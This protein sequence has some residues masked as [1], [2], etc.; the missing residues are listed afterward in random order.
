MLIKA[1][2]YK[3]YANKLIFTLPN[4][5]RLSLKTVLQTADR[6]AH[7]SMRVADRL[8]RLKPQGQAKVS[9]TGAQ[10]GLQQDVLTLD[11]PAN[12]ST[13]THTHT[14]THSQEKQKTI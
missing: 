2:G 10:V 7:L 11:V 5:N 3:S 13:C 8:A 4:P 9:H 12:K 1:C 6:P 14:H